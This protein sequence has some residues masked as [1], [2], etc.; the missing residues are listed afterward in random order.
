MRCVIE[1]F[2]RENP[3]ALLATYVNNEVQKCQSGLRGMGSKLNQMHK[4]F[5]NQGELLNLPF[6]VF[7]LP[8]IVF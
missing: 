5:I 3:E 6:I 2:R 1:K 7:L 4:I 8:I